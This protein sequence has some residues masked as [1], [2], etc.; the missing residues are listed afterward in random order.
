MKVKIMSAS[1]EVAKLTVWIAC[2]VAAKRNNMLSALC[3]LQ[4]LQVST[5][6]RF[7]LSDARSKMATDSNAHVSFILVL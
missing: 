7:G 1:I 4:S 2:S 3:N 5:D 6:D